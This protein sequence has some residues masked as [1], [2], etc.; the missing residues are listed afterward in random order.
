MTT[1]YRPVLIESAEQAEAL[2]IGT[3]ALSPGHQHAAEGRDFGPETPAVRAKHYEPDAPWYSDWDGSMPS[4]DVVG[5]TAIVPVE[6][7]EVRVI[8]SGR[9][10][11]D[12]CGCTVLEP[13]S[14]AGSRDYRRTEYRT[15][16]E[17]A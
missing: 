17:E 12:V 4:S 8:E 14:D 3:V 9:I 15:A 5:W 7:E 2:P 6:A 13:S 11:R 1:L 10:E 16:W